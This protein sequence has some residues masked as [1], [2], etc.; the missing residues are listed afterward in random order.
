MATMTKKRL[1]MMRSG[2]PR[3]W[4]KI[5]DEKYARLYGKANLINRSDGN[6]DSSKK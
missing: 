3:L 4:E 5:S 1:D 2:E 6:F